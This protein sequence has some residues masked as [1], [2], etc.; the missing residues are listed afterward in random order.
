M[1]SILDRLERDTLIERR[2]NSFDRRRFEIRLT[3]AGMISA[4]LAEFVIAEV[5]AEIAGYTSRLD[6]R[7]A[8]AVYEA[9]VAIGKRDRGASRWD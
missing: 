9:C 2:Q 7:G 3:P 8:V 4:Q 5:E 1:S 6:R